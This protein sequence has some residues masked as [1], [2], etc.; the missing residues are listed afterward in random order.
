VALYLHP[1]YVFMEWYLLKHRDN[2]TL[3]YPEVSTTL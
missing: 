3:P 2:F 1:Q